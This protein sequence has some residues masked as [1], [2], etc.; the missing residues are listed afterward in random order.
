MCLSPS[1]P[2]KAN[3]VN[4]LVPCRGCLANCIYIAN[5]EGKPWR[6]TEATILTILEKSKAANQSS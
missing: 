4:Q 5:C 2:G 1:T 6:M 3:T